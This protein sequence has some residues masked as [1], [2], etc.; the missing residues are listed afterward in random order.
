MNSCMLGIIHACM[1]VCPRTW[2]E[3]KNIC[4]IMHGCICDGI[5]EY[6]RASMH[7]C[8]FPIY[9]CIHM[10][11]TNP[12]RWCSTH[13]PHTFTYVL[14]YIHS[15]AVFQACNL[16]QAHSYVPCAPKHASNSC[17][18]CFFLVLC[19]YVYIYIY[20]YIHI[21]QIL[22]VSVLC[23]SVPLRVLYLSSGTVHSY[24]V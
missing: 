5:N 3:H 16:Y 1:L 24:F 22:C 20:I 11:S 6:I 12:W 7:A 18:I 2:G 8:V 23:A 14:V 15:V 21:L 4:I 10:I 13:K 17:L 19:M 9:K